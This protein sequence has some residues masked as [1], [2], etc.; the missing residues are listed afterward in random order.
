[1]SF[2]ALPRPVK[3]GKNGQAARK[4][5]ASC[6]S[7]ACGSKGEGGLVDE[8]A[9]HRRETCIHVCLRRRHV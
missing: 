1:M 2:K 9:W 7:G 5:S 6:A 4:Y 3:E 8:H